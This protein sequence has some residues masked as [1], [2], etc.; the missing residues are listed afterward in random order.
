M[1]ILEV[2]P[3]DKRLVKL[4]LDAHKLIN[5]QD[6]NWICPL[7]KDIEAV[8][9]PKQ[10]PAHSHGECTRWVLL[11][12]TGKPIGRVAAF[13]NEHTKWLSNKQATGGLGFFDCI[14]NQ[15]AANCL[16]DTCRRWLEA[17]GIQAMD[18]P[19]NFGER[20]RWWGLLVEG[21]HPPNY[22]QNYN[23]PY[24]RRLFEAYG[25]QNYFEQ[26]TYGRPVGS[27]ND[28]LHARANRI[29]SNEA[30]R[31]EKLNKKKL[32]SYVHAFTQV[33]NQSF[34]VIEDVPPLSEAETYTL[35]RSIMPII[36]ERLVWFAFYR[37]TPIGMMVMLPEVNELFKHLHGKFNFWAKLK[38]MYYK[39]NMRRYCKRMTGLVFGIVPRFQGRGIDAALI[40]CIESEALKPTFP[41]EWV[42]L[43]WIGDF[44]PP[45]RR[46]VEDMDF[47]VHKKHIT[48]RKIF[49]PNIPFERHPIRTFER[50]NSSNKK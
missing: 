43:N 21:F 48:Y 46:I 13:V 34:A 38:F 45:M 10:N 31:F 42:E 7:D 11:D 5:Q 30:Y 37:D 47:K 20:D 33:Y 1:T 19:I 16:F 50:R 24:Y 12:D 39:M 26:Y 15:E 27:V 4:F 14:D 17:R 28:A 41:Y 35:M 25:F 8:F 2:K 9:D 23:P 3:Q 29:F 44:N 40:S 6:P 36:D 22:Q 32:D 49:D 18:G